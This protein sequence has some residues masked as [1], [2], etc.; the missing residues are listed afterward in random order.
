[1]TF[2]FIFIVLY[3]IKIFRYYIGWKKLFRSTDL[4][5]TPNV[6]V[7]IALRNEEK[8]INNLLSSLKEQ[9]YPSDLIQ[10]I[11]VNDHSTDN[12]SKLLLAEKLDNFKIVDMA[13]GEFGKK[14]AI[15]K[16]IRLAE[17]DI[18]IT[19]DAD[20][21]FNNRWIRTM[22]SYF[23]DE[24]I[25]LVAGPVRLDNRS[26][27]FHVFQN[28]EFFSL[29]GSGAGAIGQ[30]NAIFCNA[31]N[32]AYRKNIFLELDIFSDDKIISG[33][34]VFLL[35]S[36]KRI[37]PQGILFAKQNPAIVETK[38]VE[39]LRE[40]INQRK[41]WT[42]K[43][44]HYKDFDALYTSFLIFFTNLLGVILVILSIIDINFLFYTVVYFLIKFIIDL[45]FL[46]PVIKFFKRQELIRW[47]LPFQIIYALYVV[48]IVVLSFTN[49]FE[50]KGRKHTR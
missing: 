14:Q 43:S 27:I 21:T 38:G 22:V 12:T 37:S 33:D 3:S 17:G 49:N 20:C 6:S 47:I 4:N 11:L 45:L 50:W 39:N 36:I 30:G 29:I 23:H 2:L 25:N 35:H 5:F 13:E 40:F 34:D 24:G 28:L 26:G 15:A 7:V 18:I 48:L 1:M 10:F 31:A 9:D 19:S 32:M 44:I 46:I 16:G 42:A 8:E 41:R